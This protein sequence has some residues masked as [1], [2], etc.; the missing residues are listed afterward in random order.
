MSRS[1]GSKIKALR[2]NPYEDPNV[3]YMS[4]EE[5]KNLISSRVEFDKL[6]DRHERRQLKSMKPAS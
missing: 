1:R 5:A 6:A 4:L 2:S 3:F